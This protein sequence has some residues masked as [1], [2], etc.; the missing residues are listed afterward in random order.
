MNR[1]GALTDNAHVESFFH[2]MKSD[3]IHG[4]HFVDEHT[5]ASAVRRYIPF[6][7]GRRLHSSLDYR[8][9]VAYEREM[10]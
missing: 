6:Y 5:L 2:S 4:V 7:N 10:G 9:P 1:P 8:S 3:I